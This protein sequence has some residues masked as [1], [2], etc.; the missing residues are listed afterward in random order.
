MAA[1]T[2][3]VLAIARPGADDLGSRLPTYLHPL[4]GRPLAWHAVQAAAALAPG[5]VSVVAGPELGPDLFGDLPG[6]ARV[7]DSSS[8]GVAA[9][10]AAAA[11]GRLLAVD[12]LAPTAGRA[13]PSLLENDGDALLVGSDGAVLAAWLDADGAARLVD[14]GGDLAALAALLPDAHRVVDEAVFGVRSRACLARASAAIRDRVVRRLMGEGVTFLLPDTVLVDVDVTIG[15]DTV[16]YPGAVIEGATTIG[17]ETVIGPYCR[18][19]ACRIGSGVE[20]K[21]FNYLSHTS[22]RNRAILEAYVRRGYD[23]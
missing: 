10:V 8:G 20:L 14:A 22:L 5:R 4:A 3:L 18:I 21:G 17:A 13:L 16:V 23:Q 1:R 12:A 2:G 6:G 15:R 19:V 7:L 11:G 9:A